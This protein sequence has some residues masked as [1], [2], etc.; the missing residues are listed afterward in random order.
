MRKWTLLR[1]LAA[2]ILWHKRDFSRQGRRYHTS[3]LGFY[4]ALLLDRWS[5]SVTLLT[6]L[7][8]QQPCI[9][10]WPGAQVYGFGTPPSQSLQHAHFVA[11]SRHESSLR[12]ERAFHRSPQHFARRVF[13]RVVSPA[14]GGHAHRLHAA[15]AGGSDREQIAGDA[16]YR[17]GR[18][19]AERAIRRRPHRFRRRNREIPHAAIGG[20]PKTQQLGSSSEI[21]RND[22]NPKGRKRRD[23]LNPKLRGLGS[24]FWRFRHF[25]SD[26][27]R[28]PRRCAR[29]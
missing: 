23:A 25:R 21:Q 22:L 16:L 17:A 28:E 26:R 10:S 7:S 14:P 15:H 1:S 27:R 6:T 5:S 29:H 19:C 8:D 2:R 18:A 3:V 13:L 9:P 12:Q 4:K 11:F 20:L 24:L